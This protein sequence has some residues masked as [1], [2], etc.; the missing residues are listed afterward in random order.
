MPRPIHY[1]LPIGDNPDDNFLH[2]VIIDDSGLCD[3][4]RVAENGTEA[5]QYPKNTDRPDLILT[6]VNL[7]GMNGFKFL[8]QYHQLEDTLKSRLAVLMLTTSLTPRDTQRAAT[9]C[10][11][12][13]YYTK[14]LSVDLLQAVVDAN[15]SPSPINTPSN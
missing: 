7:P 1:I 3:H 9:L 10:Y 14:P 4:V 2:Q 6:D 13:E 15:N 12:K 5:F 8:E 11:V